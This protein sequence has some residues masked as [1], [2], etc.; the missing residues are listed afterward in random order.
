MIE[1]QKLGQEVPQ[2]LAHVKQKIQYTENLSKTPK[3]IYLPPEKRQKV[4]DEL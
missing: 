1:L 2:R 4:T 3:E